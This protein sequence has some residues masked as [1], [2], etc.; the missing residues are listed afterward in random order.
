MC[1]H[2]PKKIWRIQDWQVQTWQVPVCVSWTMEVMVTDWCSGFS[3][4]GDESM[5]RGFCSRGESQRY[6]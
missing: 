1:N 6:L 5:K 4:V 3:K 2:A